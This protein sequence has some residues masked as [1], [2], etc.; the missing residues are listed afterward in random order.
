VPYVLQG[1]IEKELERMQR[2]NIIEA[3]KFSEWATPIVPVLK[4]DGTVRIC[5][6]Y[7]ITVNR[8]SK[9][10]QYPIPRLED[11]LVKLGG[12]KL[13]SKLDMSH[14]YNQLLLSEESQNILT[15][16]TH[17]G[18]F[19]VK[20]LPYGVSSAP[21][22]FQRTVESLVGDIP[23]VVC[24]LDDILIAGQTEAEHVARLNEVLD[25]LRKAGLKLKKE[26]C[27]FM[28]PEVVYIGHKIST[29]G[30]SPLGEKIEAIQ[31]VP[32]PKNVTDL[33][34][35]L[36]LLN[37]Y[38]RFLPNVA[39]LLAPLHELLRKGVVWR[40]GNRQQA[41][42]EASK[43]LLQSDRVLVHYR[44][45]SDLVLSCDSSGFGLGA[46][47]SRRLSDGSERP[48]SF[49]S[50][51]LSAAEKSYSTLDREACAVMFAVRKFHR[52]LMG[53]KFSIVTDHKPLIYL[54]SETKST[55]QM[56]SARRLRWSLELGSYD[57]QIVHRAGKDNQNADALSRLPLGEAVDEQTN[58]R[59]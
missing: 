48:I 38:H 58:A 35:F 1:K 41:A 27:V 25:R 40:W 45:D 33:Q 44:S 29:E 46:V 37:Y 32:V 54:F 18:L 16:N 3:V 8:E 2:E 59:D 9:V 34:A 23:G 21:A 36:G 6:D 12:G 17:K 52:Y 49:A 24:Y 51:S 15:L 20:R 22:I 42:F 57:Y 55:P 30:V 53:R 43:R 50:R 13:Y 39:G 11:L 5:G 7:K 31:K 10:E 26:K 28:V 4:P 19:R 56:S 14:A 47:L